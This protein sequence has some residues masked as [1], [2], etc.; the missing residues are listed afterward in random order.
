MYKDLCSGSSEQYWREEGNNKRM[1]NYHKISEVLKIFK[2][3]LM[4]ALTFY[5]VVI[6]TNSLFCLY[7]KFICCDEVIDLL[8]FINFKDFVL[9]IYIATFIITSFVVL[10]F[11]RK[12][13]YSRKKF[14]S[15]LM[16]NLL[17][18]PISALL[19]YNFVVLGSLMTNF[20]LLVVF[21]VIMFIINQLTTR[22]DKLYSIAVGE[23]N[24]NRKG[25]NKVCKKCKGK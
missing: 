15:I 6:C 5:C 10:Y 17:F 23:V 1:R 25:D 21:V 3:V 14:I 18:L 11:G 2:Y 20:Y 12:N 24:E 22:V 16:N 9:D 7:D 4:I 13:K 19:I 8:T